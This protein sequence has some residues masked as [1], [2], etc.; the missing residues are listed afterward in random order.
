MTLCRIAT[1]DVTSGSVL[2]HA[3]QSKPRNLQI[4]ASAA[5]AIANLATNEKDQVSAL[6]LV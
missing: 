2:A 6:M 5:S 1:E 3:V 4:I